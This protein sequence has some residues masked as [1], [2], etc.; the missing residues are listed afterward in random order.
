MI[1]CIHPCQNNRPVKR[2]MK[3]KYIDI[4]LSLSL[5]LL[6]TRSGLS[7]PAAGS[8]GRHNLHCFLNVAAPDR[9]RKKERGKMIGRE[10]GDDVGRRPPPDGFHHQGLPPLDASPPDAVDASSLTIE[11]C[12]RTGC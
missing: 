9:K 7:V 11:G 4:C 3:T 8:P 2:N 6:A 10:G 12:A 1:H 5:A